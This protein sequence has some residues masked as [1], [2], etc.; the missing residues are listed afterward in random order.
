MKFI[1]LK[2]N[3]PFMSIVLLN[4][5]SSV[6]FTML[7]I[8]SFACKKKGASE[9]PA[10]AKATLVSPLANSTCT[11]GSNISGGQTKITLTWNAAANANSYEIKVKNLLTQNIS[12]HNTSSNQIDVSLLQ[13][14]PYSW[15]VISK[16]GN[17]ASTATS[18]IWKFY[19]AGEATFSYAPFPADVVSPLH[20]QSLTAS[21]GKVILDWSVSDVDNDI[22]SYDVYLGTT[23][24]NM[25]IVKTALTESVA[26]DISVNA[27]TT[28]YWKVLTKDSKGNVSSSDV[29]WFKLQ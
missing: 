3:L 7:L 5:F 21:T 18:D 11:T 23:T 28:Y 17:N 13:N 20:G 26:N 15:W 8:G 2:K 1:Y 27:G 9:S 25:T 14:T 19:A 16:S 4:R 12:S 6:L 29:W 24:A 22:A 10:P